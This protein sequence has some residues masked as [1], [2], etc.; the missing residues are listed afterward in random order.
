M[1]KT[2]ALKTVRILLAKGLLG[3]DFVQ[4]FDESCDLKPDERVEVLTAA[5]Q[6]M[7]ILGQVAFD[8]SLYASCKI[9]K[10]AKLSHPS[11]SSLILT[12]KTASCECCSHKN[13]SL[14]Q[15]HS[16]GLMGGRLV[17]KDEVPEESVLK[18]A[19]KLMDE[20]SVSKQEVS[21]IVKSSLPA[22]TRVAAL[23]LKKIDSGKLSESDMR[24]QAQS[25]RIAA[26]L[27]QTGVGIDVGEA[28][29]VGSRTAK[30][31]EQTVD[32]DSRLGDEKAVK[33]A[34]KFGTYMS[35]QNIV[36]EAD[37]NPGFRKDVRVASTKSFEFPERI[38]MTE[39]RDVVE[40]GVQHAQSIHDKLVRFARKN[41][42]DGK[43]TAALAE[44]ISSKLEELWGV[45]AVA[46]EK[47]ARIA[48][49]LSAMSGLLEL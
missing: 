35:K 34:A 49:Q 8:P 27:D 16:C 10:K 6:E 31:R 47:D 46:K 45:G 11:P 17:A 28:K 23:M 2:V 9:A 26:M 22:K 29:K 20:N 25:R 38:A 19:R 36:T 48:S 24:G 15:I 42:V 5:K 18:V 7:G 14:G 40:E 30:N 21:R 12:Y 33:K 43:M 39:D 37:F 41:L 44:R 3:S 4:A 32:F 13:D 1:K